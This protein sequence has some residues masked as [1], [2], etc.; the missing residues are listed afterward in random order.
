MQFHTAPLQIV[1]K[2]SSETKNAQCV[3]KRPE[4]VLA[5]FKEPQRV[6]TFEKMP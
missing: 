4:H 5:A 3:K 2:F 1:Y 6:L